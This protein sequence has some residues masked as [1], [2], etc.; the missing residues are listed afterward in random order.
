MNQRNRRSRDR[1]SEQ[2]IGK[3]TFATG[4]H[5]VSHG[6]AQEPEI[7]VPQKATG[8]VPAEKLSGLAKASPFF[9]KMK[10][11]IIGKKEDEKK[12]IA[13]ATQEV[14][15]TK[16]EPVAAKKQAPKSVEKKAKDSK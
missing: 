8:D 10:E 5:V 12:V 6:R 14:A 9:K 15:E 1:K 2:N 11:V 7:K 4:G 3:S 13:T 16:E